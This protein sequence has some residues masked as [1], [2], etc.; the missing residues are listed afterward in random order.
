[1]HRLL[2]RAS[3]LV[4]GCIVFQLVSM[5]ASP[6]AICVDLSSQ[7]EGGACT[8]AHP[9]AKEC[10]MHHQVPGKSKPKS[11]CACRS[12]TDPA[13]AVLSSL[14]GPAALVPEAREYSA[15]VSSSHLPR[16]ASVQPRGWLIVPDSP[17]PRS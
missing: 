2:R 13:S 8:C 11:D 6:V 16:A 4:R 7:A 15:S 5:T 14:F 3:W 17:P 10:P 9:E 12:T 1:M